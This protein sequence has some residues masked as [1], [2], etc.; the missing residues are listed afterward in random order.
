MALVKKANRKCRICVD[1]ADLK[2]ACLKDPYPLANI[3]KH[4][5]NSSSLGIL[6][7]MDV[8]FEYT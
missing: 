4:V 7:F 6:L 8:Y 3:G 1:Y 2:R 5:D